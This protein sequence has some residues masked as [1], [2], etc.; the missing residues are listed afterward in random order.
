MARI[1]DR[2]MLMRKM[3]FLD[4]VD[5]RECGSRTPAVRKG[6][7]AALCLSV[8]QFRTVRN[9]L[10][11]ERYVYTEARFLEGAGQLPSYYHLTDDG[12]ALL[13]RLRRLADE[14]DAQ[15]A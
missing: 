4:Y 8:D 3:R 1:S 12:R 7:M 13:A 9:L 2:D 5:E 10:V 15:R 11:R 6:I 14:D